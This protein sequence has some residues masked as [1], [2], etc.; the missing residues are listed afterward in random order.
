[1]CVDTEAAWLKPPSHPSSPHPYPLKE[2]IWC[3]KKR[4]RK[5]SPQKTPNRPPKNTLK[6]S[7]NP[8]TKGRLTH[9]FFGLINHPKKL[10]VSKGFSIIFPYKFYLLF[11]LFFFEMISRQKKI[12]MFAITCWLNHISSEKPK[13]TCDLVIFGHQIRKQIT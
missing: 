12:Y 9:H 3:S 10:R 13:Q 2:A 1:M 11:F 5:A 7:G 4:S 8:L 6:M